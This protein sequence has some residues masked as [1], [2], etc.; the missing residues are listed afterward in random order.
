MGKNRDLLKYI[1]EYFKDKT[2]QDL[3]DELFY[4]HPELFYDI[5]KYRRFGM[6]KAYRKAIK[7]YPINNEMFFF[8]SNL[9][10]QYTGNP[11]YIYE[12]M[13]EK[14]PDFKYVWAYNGDSEIPGNPIIVERGSEE[15]Y[16]YLAQ[17][18][19]LINNTLFPNW[20]HRKGSIFLQTWHGTPY[21]KMH[22]D[23]EHKRLKSRTKPGFYVKSRGWDALLSPNHFTTEK[24]KSG[25]RYDGEVLEFGYPANDI[26]YNKKDYDA[27]RSL[28]REKLNLSDDEIAYLY[29]PT[30][31]DGG[32]MGNSMFRFDLLFNP[33]E[34]L[35]HAPENSKLLIRSHHMS[36]S[37]EK[38]SEYEKSIIDVSSW[39]DAVELMCAADVLITDY[40]SIVFDWYCSKKPVIYYV[41]DLDRYVNE[42]RGAY[43][44]LEKINCGVVCKSEEELYKNLYVMDAPFYKEFYYKF[45]SLHD[46]K[47][48]ERVIDYLLNKNKKPLKNR[49]KKFF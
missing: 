35:K 33:D 14:Y 31:R 26:F 29:A 24:L 23:I 46:G 22:W 12:K 41:P 45:C 7:K 39:D 2:K 25:F 32:Y 47:S 42:L 8:E 36:D 4:T 9:A 20:F 10:R 27:K 34:F 49:F 18:K 37:D 15:Y 40:S 17:A 19:F 13:L 16:T 5:A 48:T 1:S 44:D 28:I 43:F 6:P 21:K 30:W 38:L 3:E 11:R